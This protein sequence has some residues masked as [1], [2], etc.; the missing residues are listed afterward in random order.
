MNCRSA[1][2]NAQLPVMR[3]RRGQH[4]ERFDV[5]GLREHVGDAGREQLEAQFVHQDPQIARQAPGMA[6]HVHAGA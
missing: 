2:R 1:Q 3:G 6:G 5:A 4:R